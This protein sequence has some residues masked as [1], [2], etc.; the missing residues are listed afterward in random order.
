MISQALRPLPVQG[1][2]VRRR[3]RGK[4]RCKGGEAAGR[5]AVERPEPLEPAQHEPLRL[6]P[7]QHEPLRLRM[8]GKVKVKDALV[9][10]EL[11]ELAERPAARRGRWD[12]V[13]ATHPV[14]PRIQVNK[15]VGSSSV[16]I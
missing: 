16:F 8:I 9:A 2:D 11:V 12:T 3:I 10:P 6:E 5:A 14:I 13:V 15:S 1:N 7:A 4:K